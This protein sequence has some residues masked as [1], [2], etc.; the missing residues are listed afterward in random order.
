M[1]SAGEHETRQL[2]APRRLHRYV[3]PGQWHALERFILDRPVGSF[4]VS[5]TWQSA[6]AVN[7]ATV[8]GFNLATLNGLSEADMRVEADVTL[9]TQ[10]RDR[11]GGSRRR[12]RLLLSP[13]WSIR[14]RGP[15]RPSIATRQRLSSCCHR[16]QCSCPAIQGRHAALRRD[17]QRLDSLPERRATHSRDRRWAAGQPGSAGIAVHRRRASLTTS[18]NA[19]KLAKARFG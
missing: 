19:A 17:R 16:R 5:N 18:G 15:S 2:Q 7:P 8:T 14:R 1:R 4:T 6:A 10:H 12:T 13:P 9:A 11:P 3:H